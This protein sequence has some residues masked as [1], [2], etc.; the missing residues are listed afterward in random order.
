MTG[1]YEVEEVITTGAG[2]QRNLTPSTPSFRDSLIGGSWSL[3]SMYLLSGYPTLIVNLGR[4][5]ER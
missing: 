3:V 4:F 1:R 5:F 2:V